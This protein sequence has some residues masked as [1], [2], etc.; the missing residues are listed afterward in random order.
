MIPV[1]TPLGQQVLKD[2][3]LSLTAKQR[4][5]LIVIDG[6]RTIADV[7]Q[8]AGVQPEDVSRLLELEL[9]AGVPVLGNA[10]TQPAPL[11]RARPLG[12]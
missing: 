9:I 4:A 7:I 3:S 6:K 11:T 8:Q 5:A 1:K 10:P 12:S 2:R